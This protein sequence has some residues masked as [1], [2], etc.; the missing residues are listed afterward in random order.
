MPCTYNLKNMK[1]NVKLG[2]KKN[3]ETKKETFS[4]RE[5]IIE[6][7]LKDPY[8]QGLTNSLYFYP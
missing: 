5:Y 6:I 1:N 7:I 4:S 3:I 8:R 2:T